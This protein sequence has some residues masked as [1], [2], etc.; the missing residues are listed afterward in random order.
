M[1]QWTAWQAVIG[2]VGLVVFG[3]GI[4]VES[5]AVRWAGIGCLVVAFLIRF[6]KKRTEHRNG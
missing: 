6:M 5:A 4:R 2:A 3:Y 1:T